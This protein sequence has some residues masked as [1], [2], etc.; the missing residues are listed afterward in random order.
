MVINQWYQL[1]KSLLKTDFSK[2]K[3]AKDA[4]YR[5]YFCPSEQYQP[6]YK[7]H[8][9]DQILLYARTGRGF[10]KEE[11]TPPPRNELEAIDIEESN[12]QNKKVYKYLEQ[13]MINHTSEDKVDFITVDGQILFNVSSIQVVHR[14]ELQ[15]KGIKKD[16]TEKDFELGQLLYDKHLDLY[17]DKVTGTYRLKDSIDRNPK[18][19]SQYYFD[20]N[21]KADSWM[22]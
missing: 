16:I 18:D 21:E 22:I 1:H 6:K 13:N 4:G 10:I 11:K 14:L 17:E 2:H 9:N 15:K 8:S 12:K 19:K 5:P 3:K 7:I 20:T